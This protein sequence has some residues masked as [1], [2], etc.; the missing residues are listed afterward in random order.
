M[1]ISPVDV[2]PVK[3]LSVTDAALVYALPLDEIFKA[4]V[5]NCGLHFV[6]DSDFQIIFSVTL[7]T[8]CFCL[9]LFISMNTA[10]ESITG[11]H[12]SN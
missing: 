11:P 7:E 1:E 12:V 8:S 9:D 5:V 3:V 4:T 10:V 6:K 2:L